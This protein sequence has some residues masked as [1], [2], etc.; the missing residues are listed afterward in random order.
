M[1][2]D[3]ILTHSFIQKYYEWLFL[4][5]EN[6]SGAENAKVNIEGLEKVRVSEEEV[7]RD[8]NRVYQA[9]KDVST[10]VS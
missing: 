7:M 4:C 1:W 5:S 6:Y 9:E 2:V 10:K 3:I 8:W